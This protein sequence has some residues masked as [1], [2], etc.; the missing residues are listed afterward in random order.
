MVPITPLVFLF[1][2]GPPWSLLQI[3]QHWLSPDPAKCE[4]R[5]I[6][7]AMLIGVLHAILVVPGRAKES[8]S[9]YFEGAGYG[10]AAVISLIVV[11]NCFGEAIK[12]AGLAAAIGAF[13]E[14]NPGLLVPL[15]VFGPW[16]FAFISG[17]GIASTQS[18][19]IFFHGPAV[20]LDANPNDVGAGVSVGA[21][22][23]R[24]M[25]PVSAVVMMCATLT[26]LKPFD[27]VKRLAVPLL[28]G[29]IGIV[30]LR[31]LHVI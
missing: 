6:A 31:V 30:L 11:A 21:A 14:R 17:S 24:T 10:F 4:A 29:L 28:A 19:Y 15:S 20:A 5:L 23:G 2:A 13:I 7:V 22:A 26:N 25:S 18:L 27:I 12:G 16:F 8:M 3:P 9:K 1:L